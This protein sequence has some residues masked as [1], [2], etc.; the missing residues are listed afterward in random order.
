M[1]IL[2]F[3]KEN[4][5]IGVDQLHFFLQ[6]QILDSEI[7]SV[8]KTDFTELASNAEGLLGGQ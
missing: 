6:G 5:H 8:D 4:H 1:L 7:T 2:H 3:H